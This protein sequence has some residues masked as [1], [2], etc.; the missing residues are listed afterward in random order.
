MIY[1]TQNPATILKQYWGHEKF[2][3]LQK[4]AI[5]CVLK[6]EDS[7]LV[8]PTGGGKSAC[9]QV[10][11]LALNA[12]ALVVSPLIALMKDQ[13]DGLRLSGVP[14]AC[15]NSTMTIAEKR[16][17]TDQLKAGELKLLYIAGF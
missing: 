1:Q 4:E 14:A 15:I 10:P 2:L 17:V 16:L 7:L 6:N 5:E 12:L 3:P 13:V 11:A 8:L 9:Y